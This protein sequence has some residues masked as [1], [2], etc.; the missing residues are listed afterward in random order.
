MKTMFILMSHVLTE[1]QMNDAQRNHGVTDFMYLPKELQEKFS[2]VPPEL[3]S[4]TEYISPFLTFVKN[5][6]KEGDMV[7]IQGEMGVVVSIVTEL[8]VY[9]PSVQCVYATTQR[10]MEEVKNNDGSV[11]KVSVFKHVRFRLY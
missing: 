9:L 3:E 11:T 4:L 1:D 7:C 6:A 5:N 10:V 2:N 8:R